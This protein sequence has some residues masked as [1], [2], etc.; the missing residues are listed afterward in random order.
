MDGAFRPLYRL[1]TPLGAI[2]LSF[3]SPLRRLAR[4]FCIATLFRLF[5]HFSG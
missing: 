4:C 5:I 3:C 2:A 1:T